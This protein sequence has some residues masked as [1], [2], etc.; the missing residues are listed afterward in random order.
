MKTITFLLFVIFFKAILVVANYGTINQGGDQSPTLERRSGR[1]RRSSREMRNQEGY[2]YEEEQPS[3]S[4]A[5][6]S[7]LRSD[8]FKT[9]ANVAQGAIGGFVASQVMNLDMQNRRG[10]GFGLADHEAS[11]QF[12]APGTLQ[13]MTGAAVLSAVTDPAA[14]FSTVKDC[15]G[16]ACRSFSFNRLSLNGGREEDEEQEVD[17]TDSNESESESS[18]GN[19]RLGRNRS[20]RFKER[21]LRMENSRR[22]RT[23]ARQKS[24]ISSS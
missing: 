18:Q 21:A 14:A 20:K 4:S 19:Q 6:R 16:E 8:S 5:S 13:A 7:F 17:E 2:G 11:N 12:A 15:F 3:S 1:N 10:T 9:L 23:L 24:N 22:K